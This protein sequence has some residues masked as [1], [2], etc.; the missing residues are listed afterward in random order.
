[1]FLPYLAHYADYF[2]QTDGVDE[3]EFS[4][5]WSVLKSMHRSFL[6]SIIIELCL[7][8]SQYTKPIIFQ[9]LHEAVEE[10][11]REA[12]RF[13]QALWDAVGDFSVSVFLCSAFYM[14]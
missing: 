11:H 5:D 8:N 3:P 7:P 4:V 14:A 1:M 9:V 12:K 2:K 6:D 13:P 10:A